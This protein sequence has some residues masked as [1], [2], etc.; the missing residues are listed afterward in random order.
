M[1]I[2]D[3]VRPTNSCGGKPGGARCETALV[4]DIWISHCEQVQISSY[5][6]WDREVYECSLMCKCG[7]FEEYDDRLELIDE[8]R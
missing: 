4:L 5:E 6:Y 8:I 2:G 7:T 1:K 3:L